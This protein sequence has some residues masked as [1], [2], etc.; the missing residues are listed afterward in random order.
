[1]TSGYCAVTGEWCESLD[2]HHIIPRERG[3]L[4]GPTVLLSPTAHATL[5]RVFSNNQR[6]DAFASSVKNSNLVYQLAGYLRQSKE[7]FDRALPTKITVSLSPE[8]ITKLQ[9]VAVDMGISISAVATEIIRKV[10]N[11]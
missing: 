9:A 4:E 3:G 10:I 11:K 8:E 6:L 2:E 5:H 1:M 7:Q